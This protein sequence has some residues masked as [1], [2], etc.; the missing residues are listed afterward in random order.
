[1][2]KTFNHYQ[3]KTGDTAVYPEAGTGSGAALAYVGLGLGEAGEIQNQ[4]KK[5][6]RDDAGKLTD[7]R[8]R[9]IAKELGD[10]LYYVAR[11]ATEIGVPLER[12]AEMNLS[13][14]ADRRARN[15]LGGSGDNR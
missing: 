13:K 1:M 12:I 15:K 2:A 5:V 14:L 7:D 11:C 10:L 3:H 6:L 8:R 4:L 9:E